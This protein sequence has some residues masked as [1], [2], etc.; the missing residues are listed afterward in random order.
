MIKWKI[1]FS[2]LLTHLLTHSL[3]D[4]RDLGDKKRE[5]RGMESKTSEMIC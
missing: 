4:G 3:S 5:K 1:F 2:H